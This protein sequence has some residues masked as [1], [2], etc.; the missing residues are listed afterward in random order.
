MSTSG[1]TVPRLFVVMASLVIV[2]GLL[3]A[4]AGRAQVA[5][6]APAIALTSFQFSTIGTQTAGSPFVVTVT[7]M[8]RRGRVVTG[9]SGGTLSGITASSPS[10]A[11]PT[12]GALTWVDGVGTATV[13]ATRSQTGNSLRIDFGDIS[14]T[15]NTFTVLPGT[16]T[17]LYFSDSRNAFNGQPVDTKFDAKISSSLTSRLPVKVLATDALGNRASG[18]PVTISA[19]G[20]TLSGVPGT[21]PSTSG[22]TPGVAPYGE[23][24]FG[25]LA[26]TPLGRY[27]LGAASAGL[28]SATSRSFE[29]VADLA[30]CTGSVCRNN[31]EFVSSSVAQRTYGTA[32]RTDATFND[33]VALTTSFITLDPGTEYCAGDAATFGKTTEVRVQDAVP[34]GVS[35]AKPD[36][37]VAIIFPK[38]TL[39]NLGL[40]SRDAGSYNVCL[41][42][43][44]L[45]DPAAFAPWQSTVTSESTTLQDARLIDGA[46]WGWVPNC[47]TSLPA[48][49]PCI[50]LKTKNAGQLQS[51]LGLT[52]PQFAALG[53]QSSD[54]AIVVSKPWP[55]D[56]KMGMK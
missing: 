47:S 50:T 45:G 5:L 41:G 38:S 25:D 48:G 16:A 54:L 30:L 23:V 7:A 6:G 10:G 20:G 27:T 51:A 35:A 34:G 33:S 17:D 14:G 46:Y 44:Y 36:F 49:N 11:A 24:A 3:L 56:G 28:V 43:T 37:L 2:T 22:G 42:A 4:G 8:D 55:W 15:S 12:I 26:I 32:T 31:G 53:F 52:K 19:S 21:P 13:T 39:Q 29:I 9:H 1:V 40:A 18:V